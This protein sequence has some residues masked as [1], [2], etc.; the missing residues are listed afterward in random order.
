MYNWV[1]DSR[2]ISC[3]DRDRTECRRPVPVT[4]IVKSGK[5]CLGI[6]VKN[7]GKKKGG[8]DA[9]FL[10]IKFVAKRT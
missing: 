2:I 8:A 7:G 10:S 6:K 5:N 3:T 9:S 1:D 4:T